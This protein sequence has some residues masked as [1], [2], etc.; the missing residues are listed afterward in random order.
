MPLCASWKDEGNYACL[1]SA[2]SEGCLDKLSP[3][4]SANMRALRDTG[5]SSD[6]RLDV[7]VDPGA[8]ISNAS[9]VRQQHVR[10]PYT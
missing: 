7:K 10:D 4:S 1:D 5:L 6:C 8:I 3:K 9:H 2:D